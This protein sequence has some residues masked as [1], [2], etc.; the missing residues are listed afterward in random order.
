MHANLMFADSAY[1]KYLLKNEINKIIKNE[2]IYTI[3]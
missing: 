3:Y 1:F 2:I